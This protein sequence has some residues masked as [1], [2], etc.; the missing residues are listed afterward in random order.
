ML[1]SDERNINS[2]ISTI[3]DSLTS[4]YKENIHTH[5]AYLP[6]T[7]MFAKRLIFLT[8]FL[9]ENVEKIENNP[10]LTSKSVRNV[11]RSR[12]DSIQNSFLIEE[13]TTIVNETYCIWLFSVLSNDCNQFERIFIYENTIPSWCHWFIL[14][15]ENIFWRK[16]NRS[17]LFTD[18]IQSK[19]ST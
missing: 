7:F 4:E 10:K 2:T 9:I 16:R 13:L 18:A 1:R 19:I 8:N 12:F 6:G 14:A 5:D 11:E 17:W 3:I 15:C